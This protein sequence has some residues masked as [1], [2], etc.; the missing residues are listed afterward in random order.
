VGARSAEAFA[1]ALSEKMQAEFWEFRDALPHRG[2]DPEQD[3]RPEV[4][5]MSSMPVCPHPTEAGGLP[6]GWVVRWKDTDTVTAATDDGRTA[7]ARME[8]FLVER[9]VEGC[10]AGWALIFHHPYLIIGRVDAVEVPTTTIWQH[11]AP[12]VPALYEQA[13]TTLAECPDVDGPERD[14]RRYLLTCY[15]LNDEAEAAEAVLVGLGGPVSMY[16]KALSSP[17]S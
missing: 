14:L 11:A 7:T 12:S 13:V 2:L 10:S 5:R 9:L 4:A 16:P 6:E 15:D 1:E 3:G 8:S 17:T